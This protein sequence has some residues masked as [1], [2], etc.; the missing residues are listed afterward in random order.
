VNPVLLDT[1]VLS[2]LVRPRPDARVVAFVAALDAPLLS[3]L[4]IHELT[5]GA[6]RS[7]D[8]ER[9]ER[10]MAWVDTVRRR[11]AGRVIDVDPDVAEIAGRLRAVADGGG[12][13]A[14]PIDALIAASAM[15]RGAAVATRNVRD[16]EP[17]GVALVDP[18][19]R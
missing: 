17:L 4:T 14:D 5:F 13:P 9:R 19:G 15:V 6:A 3:V 11:F 18:W 10:L 16:F 2:E 7:P 8:P 1:N 12:R